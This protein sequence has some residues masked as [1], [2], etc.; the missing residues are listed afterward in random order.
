[1]KENIKIMLSQEQKKQIKL[2]AIETNK[3]M[4]DYVL[5]FI[6]NEKHDTVDT[7]NRIKE[8]S[9]QLSKNGA[10][11]TKEQ[12]EQLKAEREQLRKEQTLWKKMKHLM[13]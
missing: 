5:S 2:G 13:I 3:T 6:F 4:S 10:T 7:T 11:M 1:M 12:R 9:E 8:I